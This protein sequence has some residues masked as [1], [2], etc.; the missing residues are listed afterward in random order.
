VEALTSSGVIERDIMLCKIISSLGSVRG[1]KRFQKSMFI[2]KALGYPVPEDFI[3]GNY[4][5]YSSRLQWELDSLVRDGVIVERNVAAAG[6]P[7]EY[8]YSVGSEGNKLLDRVKALAAEAEE[9][10]LGL[11]EETDP[12]SAIGNNEIEALTGFLQRTG[13]TPVRDLELWSSILYLR[14]SEKNDE[15]LISF[16]RY[17]KPQYSVEDIRRG[18]G[19]VEELSN[20][21]FQ[22]VRSLRANGMSTK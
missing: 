17:L 19:G 22:K 14:Q 7:P 4:G 18:F 6:Q 5:V 21:S 8:E 20:L 12:I 11:S 16:L 2:A 3:W 13:G 10:G 15:N 9:A 1:R